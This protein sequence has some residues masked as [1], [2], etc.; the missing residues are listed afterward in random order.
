MRICLILLAALAAYGC[1][2]APDRTKAPATNVSS[3]TE[4]IGYP[5]LQASDFELRDA[6]KTQGYAVLSGAD[7]H[8]HTV[9]RAKGYTE[10]F[11]QLGL[12]QQSKLYPGVRQHSFP[13]D[14]S[15]R[16]PHWVKFALEG[17]LGAEE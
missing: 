12:R 5:V 10:V 3:A 16:F 15:Q 2:R 17:R 8:P 6:H 7:E 9:A 11:D 14:Y 4:A 1:G 13:A